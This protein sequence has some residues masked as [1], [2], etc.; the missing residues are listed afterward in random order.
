MITTI[1]KNDYPNEIWDIF[2]DDPIDNSRDDHRRGSSFYRQSIFII[3]HADYPELHGYWESNTYL[4]NENW[5][6]NEEITTLDR[7]EQGETI[8][9]KKVWSKIR[10]NKG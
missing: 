9:I 1:K 4:W 8:I 10:T 7:V 2:I 5:S 3:D 6:G